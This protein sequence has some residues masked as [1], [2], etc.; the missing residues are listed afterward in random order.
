[1]KNLRIFQNRVA[2]VHRSDIRLVY[3]RLGLGLMGWFLAIHLPAQDQL[4]SIPD[5]DPSYQLSTLYPAEGFEVNL[6]ASEPMVVKPIQ[7]N[8]DEKGRLWVVG[9]NQY[10]QPKPGAE[11]T[12]KVYILEDTDGD[13]RADTSII[14]ADGLRVPTAI[15]PGDGGVY[16]ANSTE[17]LHLKDTDGDGK[18]DHREVLL[19]GFGTG[20]THHLIHT[21]R[22]GPDG[23]LYFNQSIY[24]YSHVETPYG[25]RR[26]EGGGV[27]RYNPQT[28]ELEVYARGLV[29]P[30]GL[31]FNQYGQSF[32]TDGAGSEGI[33]YGFQ[34]ATYVTAPGAERII[35][36]LNPGQPKHSGLDFITGRHMPR[37]WSGS[38]ITNDFRANRINRFSLEKLE[39]GYISRQEED[40]LYSDNV[41]FRPVDILQGPDG[42]VYVA[43]WY[44]PI[45]Q[46]GEVDFRDP[47]RDHENGRIWRISKKDS[48]SVIVPDLAG[49]SISELLDYLQLPEAWTRD[50]VRRLLKEKGQ[51]AVLESLDGWMTN[52][53]P[54]DPGYERLLLEGFWVYQSLGVTR[55]QALEK[56]LDASEPLVRAAAVR[57]L[58]FQ[59]DDYSDA[60]QYLVRAVEDEDPVVRLEA[61]IALRK[62]S[63]PGAAAVATNALDQEMD[64]NIDFALW[65][66]VRELEGVWYPEYEAN[67]D[68]FGGNVKKAFALKSITAPTAIIDLVD[69]YLGG[70]LPADYRKDFFGSVTKF[71]NAR[72]LSTILS[73]VLQHEDNREELLDVLINSMEQRNVHPETDLS[74]IAKLFGVEDPE[75]ARKSI[76]LASLWGL[77]QYRPQFIEWAKR[78]DQTES[79][80]GI[81]ALASLGDDKSLEALLEL[82]GKEYGEEIRSTAISHLVSR[83]AKAAS[84]QAVSLLSDLDEEEKISKLLSA[85][86]ANQ[87]GVK[88]L[89]RVL[90][91]SG[92]ASDQ[93]S[94]VGLQM[95]STMSNRRQE[96]EDIKTLKSVFRTSDVEVKRPTMPQTLSEWEA[97]RLELDIKAYGDPVR[98]E[99]VYRKLGCASC[100]AI[101][102][103]GGKLGTDLS[104]LGANAPTDYIISSVLSPGNEIKDGYELNQVIKKNGNVV[105]GYMVRET[106]SEIVLRDVVGNEVSVPKYQISSHQNVPGSLMPPGLTSGLTREEF[107]DLIGFLS[108]IGE[109]GDFRVPGNNYIRYWEVLDPGDESPDLRQRKNIETVVQNPDTYDWTTVYS[110]V[111]GGLPLDEL[112]DLPGEVKLLK[113]SV[114]VQSPGKVELIFDPEGIHSLWVD[115]VPLEYGEEGA[116]VDLKSGI[117]KF[118]VALRSDHVRN[119]FKVDIPEGSGGAGRA[120]PIHSALAAE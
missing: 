102:G 107:V 51:K 82:A 55:E 119:D 8:W 98:G 39:S 47:R 106:D 35:R 101:G 57:S 5:A 69:M 26:L 12:G 114:E 53:D 88:E 113:F 78:D 71:G 77:E 108:K 54:D 104:S 94:R 103:A 80:T 66:T 52:L 95:I 61:V 50:Q 32:L 22:W 65:Q 37:E 70:Q 41:A 67:K 120:R 84:M 34:G 81:A 64:Q 4:R 19:S 24:I 36:G 83:D 38:L 17:V 59:Y 46:H 75:V 87:N 86:F 92:G 63:D 73:R 76:A 16:V 40:L 14:F 9:S 25:V 11:P 7:M 48:P 97:D 10:P 58:F 6:F 20:D 43:D 109:P 72:S 56:L 44:N 115:G 33:H 1:M 60:Y 42:A 74:R 27:W 96:S 18:A 117:R 100:H 29:N 28:R 112:D 91:E 93:V 79:E 23:S 2:A 15:L 110:N 105:M 90:S 62:A 85:F 68:Y 49:A 45:I 118:V 89:G 31:Q 116:S 30:W 99:L 3:R 111:A 13:G 21:F